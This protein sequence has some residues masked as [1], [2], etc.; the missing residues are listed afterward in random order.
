MIISGTNFTGATSVTIGGVA[1]TSFTVNSATQIT[2]TTPAGTAG[3]ANVAVTNPSGT[4]TG[5]GFYTYYG[6]PTVTGISPSSG[7]TAGGTAVT[8]TGTN[9]TGTTSVTIGGAAATGVTVNSA[10]QITA[11]T[12]AGTAGMANVVVTTPGGTGTGTGLYTYATAPGA[13]TG[14]TATPGNAQ[15]TVTFTAPASNGG[16]AIT[17]Y[18]ATSSPGGLTGSCA[19]PTACAITVTGLTNG[20]AYT[21]TVTAINAL[22]TG[23]TSSASAPVTP[24]ATPTSSALTM[25]YVLNTPVTIDLASHIVGSAVS[26]TVAPQHGT[27]TVN[28]TLVTYTPANNFF[29]ND[30]F[31]YVAVNGG[32]TSAPSV[33]SVTFAGTRPNPALD[34]DVN[35]LATSEIQTARLF[36]RAQIANYQQRL[37]QLHHPLPSGGD[38]STGFAPGRASAIVQRARGLGAPVAQSGIVQAGADALQSDSAQPAAQLA[39]ANGGDSGVFSNL[40]ASSLVSALSASSIT[41]NMA[42]MTGS[43]KPVHSDDKGIRMW[44]AGNVRIGSKGQQAGPTIDY[45]TDGVTF[46]AD[47][48]FGDNLTLGFG[49]GYARDKSTVGT[50]GTGSISHGGSLAVYGSYQFAK[51]GFLDG[52]L[53]Y[54]ELNLDTTRYVSS[55]NEFALAN[56][57]GSQVFGS[58]STG[59]DYRDQSTILSRYVRYDFAVDRLD[60]VTESGAS[61]A[62]LSYSGQTSKTQQVALGLRAETQRDVSFGMVSLRTR[63][64]YQ[65]H[66]EDG[67]QATVSYADLL[68]SPYTLLIS[69]TTSNYVLLGLGSGFLLDSGWNI[70]LDIQWAHG[71]GD[72]NSRALFIR[73]TKQLG[74]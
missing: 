57:S 74:G 1:A 43:N 63:V 17:S 47:R 67:S 65:R 7:S 48:Q 16:S 20:T 54:G 40:L 15:A 36:W 41:L 25:N 49:I 11:T 12:P 53:G 33:V 68:G 18:T 28:G 61:I 32:L 72:N 37:E 6:A 22:G 50:D 34:P 56:R 64:E 59:Y 46:G 19:G 70:D 13:P 2:A 45:T 52:V 30:A 29:G 26:V 14:V 62:A 38:G 21:F 60:S 10:T 24:T 58:L 69:N 4:G 3:A 5:V 44:G 71:S 55:F 39:L 73:L 23:A 66:I 35:S 51:G 31:T 27:V 42:T 8:I 9:F